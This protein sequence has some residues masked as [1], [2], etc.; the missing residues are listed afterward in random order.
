MLISRVSLFFILLTSWIVIW[1]VVLFGLISLSNTFAIAWACIYAFTWLA[2]GSFLVI[3]YL[4]DAYIRADN[5]GLA[6]LIQF[7]AEIVLRYRKIVERQSLGMY[8]L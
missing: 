2:L 3:Q 6:Y 8:T 4:G 5:R 7:Y 1:I